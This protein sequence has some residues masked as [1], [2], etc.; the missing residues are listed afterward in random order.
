M[1]RR[2]LLLL[3]IVLTDKI[4]LKASVSINSD[5]FKNKITSADDDGIKP[6]IKARND[7]LVTQGIKDDTLKIWQG[8]KTTAITERNNGSNIW[9]DKF[10]DQNHEDWMI[11]GQHFKGH[12]SIIEFG[13]NSF[14]KTNYTGYFIPDFMDLNQ[15]KSYEVNIN[16]LSY[17]F[18]LQ[19]FK[20]TIG[21]VT[22][23]G[24]N[25]NDYHFSNPYTIVNDGGH[26][27]PS[28][29]DENGLSKTKLSTSFI[30]APLFIE[31][32]VP[33]NGRNKRVYFSTGIIGGM[34]L[35]SY[36]KVKRYTRKEKIHEDFNIN[37]YRYGVTARIGYKGI[38]LFGTYYKTTFF[39]GSRGPE[40]YPFT[41]GI[42]LINR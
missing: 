5:A 14:A 3:M 31:F 27:M 17:S 37:P 16:I 25:F 32:Q 1:L 4:N 34:K 41:I 22:G 30:T 18:G 7:L 2:I 29:L 42:G 10:K 20:N 38:N 15:N 13:I 33:L 35:G 36:T 23:L 12:L 9:Y 19:K 6:P 21:I 24:F 28:L 40:M 39:K 11:E 8:S 26:V